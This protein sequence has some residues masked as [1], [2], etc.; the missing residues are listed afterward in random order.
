MDAPKFQEPSNEEIYDES[1]F[2]E[3]LVIQ[4]IL[5]GRFPL[6]MR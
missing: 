4:M 2:I 6:K 1:D 3:E 5:I